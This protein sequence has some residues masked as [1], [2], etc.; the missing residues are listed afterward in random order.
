MLRSRW[1]ALHSAAYDGGY[2][3]LISKGL[4]ALSADGQLFS[5]TGAGL[6][7]MAAA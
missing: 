2:G 4:F 6:W 7:A 1:P 3:S 5:V